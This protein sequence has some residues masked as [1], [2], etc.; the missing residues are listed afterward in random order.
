MV[1]APKK[2]SHLLAPAGRQHLGLWLIRGSEAGVPSDT[3]LLSREAFMKVLRSERI[4]H[5]REVGRA[6]F[7]SRS[8]LPVCRPTGQRKVNA[9]PSRR[10]LS[11]LLVR[12]RFG[13]SY[14]IFSGAMAFERSWPR[15]T[16]GVAGSP[17]SSRHA[18]I[19]RYSPRKAG[20]NDACGC[21]ARL[22][23]LDRPKGIKGSS[24]CA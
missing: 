1:G 16:L 7:V 17:S 12:K 23:Y 13:N 2:H 8:Q 18:F 15:G 6:R 22:S 11:R 10:I 9:T 21:A 19:S 14:R 24:G 3:S 5:K 20:R 4:T